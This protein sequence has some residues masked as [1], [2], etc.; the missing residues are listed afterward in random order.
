ML[1]S[2]LDK[3]TK[4]AVSHTASQ[5]ATIK[6]TN[7]DFDTINKEKVTNEKMLSSIE[8]QHQEV[9]S[10]QSVVI[11]SLLLWHVPVKCSLQDTSL[12]AQD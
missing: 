1:V 4:Q 3:V 7:D 10:Q 9:T 11:L 8:Q 6:R 12:L 2:T 5:E